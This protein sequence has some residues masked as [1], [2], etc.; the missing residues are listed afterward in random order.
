[1]FAP[2]SPVLH[3]VHHVALLVTDLPP[4]ERFY[5]AA[6]G[7]PVLRRW[8]SADGR[9]ERAIWFDLG[10]GAFLALELGAP[11]AAVSERGA[12]GLDMVALRIEPETRGA[13]H[14][15][16]AESGHPVEQ[17]TAYTIY[18]R[19]PGGNRVGLSHWPDRVDEAT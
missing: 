14:A 10:A 5:G 9:G 19:D 13:W 2:K 6:L 16:L 11:G 7:L 3:G 18:T 12:L 15:R 4:F 17:A 8:P 1:M